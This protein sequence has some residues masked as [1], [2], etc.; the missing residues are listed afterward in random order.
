MKGIKKIAA[1][2]LAGTMLISLVGCGEKKTADENEVP[3]LVYYVP[4]DEQTDLASVM[5]EV[6]K[7]TEAKIG[8]KIDMK[9]I[10]QSSFSER[11]KMMM[12]SKTEFDLT[13]TGY[14]NPFQ[15]AYSSGGLM[16]ITELLKENTP[17]I[18]DTLPDYA[19]EAS[20]FD[21]KIYAVP[22]QQIWANC[23][24]VGLRKDLVEKYNF[25]INS[26]KTIEDV[27]PFWDTILAN[28]PTIMPLWYNTTY[29]WWNED[30]FEDITSGVAYDRET[31]EVVVR[32]A[33]DEWK[34]YIEKH[35]EWYE[36]GYIRKDFETKG[37]ERVEARAGKF[38]SSFSPYKPNVESA[39]KSINGMD[40]YW[41]NLSKPYITRSA[42]N[43]TMTA[44]SATAKHPVEAVKYIELVNTDKDLYRLICHGI[45][46]KH[47]EK[48][49]ENRIKY[50]PD[51]G[52]CPNGD[53]KFGNQFNAYGVETDP[54]DV[55]EQTKALNDSAEISPIIG[56]SLSTS[57]IEA[58]I[59][60]IQGVWKK[61]PTYSGVR[62]IDWEEYQ[63]ALK[64]AGV[65]TVCND[66]KAQMEKSLNK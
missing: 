12:A 10:D 55:W 5:E 15:Q 47:Y 1:G 31:N 61:Y 2:I 65:E 41:I 28:E 34:D 43:G 6:N 13:L 7:I 27:Y 60:Q 24:A 46:G 29:D 54:E 8:A 57:N 11:M 59:A 62:E 48:V 30:K 32:Y 50:I 64:D 56:F 20:S 16:D 37:E 14:V 39:E 35:R 25:D 44:V 40:A 45:E 23:W 3:T 26:V 51:S 9:F 19:W 36:K 22:N 18:F 58:E 4:G 53:W 66:I 17:G 52:Y 63:K 42:V 38:A 49:S 21:G 33:T